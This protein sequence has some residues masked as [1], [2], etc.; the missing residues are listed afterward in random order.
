M[1]TNQECI[2][3]TRPWKV[4]GEGPASAGVELSAQGFNEGKGK[5]F[6]AED[7]RFTVGKDGSVYAIA[8]GW[9]EKPLT[10]RSLA[11]G[12]TESGIAEVKLLGSPERVRWE[13]TNDG[14]LIT[15]PERSLTGESV[16]ASVFKITLARK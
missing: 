9:P 4:F 13:Q 12:S 2:F 5:P 15:P 1:A 11:S 3:G 6:T 7:V 14:L 10:I 8:M 16:A